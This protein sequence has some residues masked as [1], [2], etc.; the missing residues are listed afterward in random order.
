MIVK[1]LLL[2]FVCI[3]ASAVSL[4]VSSYAGDEIPF[5]KGTGFNW[6]LVLSISAGSL[7]AACI[8]SPFIFLLFK[9]RRWLAA[10]LSTSP[11]LLLIDSDNYAEIL[12]A[13]AVYFS[14]L[15]IGL[16]LSTLFLKDRKN[17]TGL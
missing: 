13:C 2:L 3:F 10:L 8:T 6:W 7:A 16:W 1:S 5:T 17:S 11:L 15:M 4:V 14:L 9:R 12:L